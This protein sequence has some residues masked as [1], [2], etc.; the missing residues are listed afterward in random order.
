VIRTLLWQ[1]IHGIL[2]ASRL[3]HMSSA[4]SANQDAKR[5]SSP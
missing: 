4:L 1:R 2:R 5:E 3:G